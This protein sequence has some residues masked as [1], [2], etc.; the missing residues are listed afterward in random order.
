MIKLD[1]WDE[2]IDD[3]TI[4][5]YAGGG[6][7]GSERATINSSDD[8]SE[9]GHKPD[10]YIQCVLTGE[11]DGS[12]GGLPEYRVQESHHVIYWKQYHHSRS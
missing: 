3:K 9:V 2:E 11:S 4:K 6:T 5:F 8:S 10:G 1:G 12:V 7:E